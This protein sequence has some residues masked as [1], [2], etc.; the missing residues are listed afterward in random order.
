[1]TTHLAQP[2]TTTPRCR[3]AVRPQAQSPYSSKQDR[4]VALRSGN[5]CYSETCRFL[6]PQATRAKRVLASRNAPTTYQLTVPANQAL[7]Q[8]PYRLVFQSPAPGKN[9][10]CTNRP[11]QLGLVPALSSCRSASVHIPITHNA[12]RSRP[13]PVGYGPWRT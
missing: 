4:W 6:A 3:D 7:R 12:V 11:G 1:M 9:S 2:H 8:S 5:P 13:L 10:G